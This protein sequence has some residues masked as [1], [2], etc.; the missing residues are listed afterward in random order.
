[1]GDTSLFQS[2]R[3]AISPG[4]ARKALGVVIGFCE[5]QPSGFLKIEEGVLLGMLA[6]RLR[7]NCG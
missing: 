2:Q 5:N 4:E 3:R 7:R 1:M 6:E